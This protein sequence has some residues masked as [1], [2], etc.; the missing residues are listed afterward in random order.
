MRLDEVV[1]TVD[2]TEIGLTAGAQIADKTGITHGLLSKRARRGSGALEEGF[3]IGKELFS[4]RH[5]EAIYR[6]IPISQAEKSYFPENRKLPTSLGMDAVRQLILERAAEL[7]R[8]LS[9]LSKKINR[10]H[11]YLQQFI[12]RGIPRDL[13]ETVR[14]ALAKELGV[15]EERLREPKLP[16]VNHVSATFESSVVRDHPGDKVGNRASNKLLTEIPSS[17]LIGERDLPVFGTSQGGKGAV[18]VTSDPVDWV[19]RPQPLARVKDAYGIIIT[20]DSMAPELRSGDIALVN[21]HLP[22]RAGHTCVFR[23]ELPDHTF[24]S[25][26]KFLR[27]QTADAWHVSE[28]NSDED[29]KRRDF[30]LKK[31]EWQVCHVKVGSYSRG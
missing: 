13:P 8:P 12:H 14:P 17:Q 1:N 3:D 31:S 5:G 25:C 21:P 4:V 11:A 18:I 20:E 29:G 28:W 16:A 15:P 9:D 10:N 24:L 27:R 23:S 26:T 6:T 2:Q 19:A 7:E 22:P 30:T